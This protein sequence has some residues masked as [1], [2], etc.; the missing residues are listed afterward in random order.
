M[1]MKIGY[2]VLT[3]LF[4]LMMTASGIMYLSGA[5][6]VVEGF[7]HLGYPDYFRTMLG[8]CKVLGAVALLVPFVP[9][10]LREWAYAGFAIN[11]VSAAASHLAAGDGVST[12]ISPMVGLGILLGSHQLWHRL[13][14]G[15]AAQPAV[16]PAAS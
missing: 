16:S 5:A 12:A 6:P 10:T 1:K 3:G 8:I 2:W 14:R 11:L 13:Q 7:R 15:E 9:R 4:G